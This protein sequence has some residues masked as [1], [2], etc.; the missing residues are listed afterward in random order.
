MDS[1]RIGKASVCIPVFNGMDNLPELIKSLREQELVE[2]EIVA[3][4][5]TS[6][7][8][9]WEYL[10]SQIDIRSTQIPTSEFSHGSTRQRLAEL[11]SNEVVIFLTQDATPSHSLFAYAHVNLHNSVGERVGAV[12]GTQIP[13]L[14]SPAAI[15]Q[16][17]KRTFDCLG[18]P[19]GIVIF[20]NDEMMKKIYRKRSIPFLSDVNVSYKKSVL[21][22][23]V[24]F[25][26]VSYAEDQLMAFDLFE[27][28]FEIVFSPQASVFH[29]NE[30]PPFK[31][32][33][34]IREEFVGAYGNLH[35]G[36]P[37]KSIVRIVISFIVNLRHDLI[38]LIKNRKR[39][40]WKWFVSE[41]LKCPIY[42]F[43]FEFGYRE[44]AK[45]LTEKMNN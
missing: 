15:A 39:A 25:Q 32:A 11:A 7:D 41:F 21:E 40:G 34:R 38:Y 20:R 10:S 8:G 13:R 14:N 12:L 28:G 30:I 26:N 27:A 45:L 19:T 33:V 35:S 31:Y 36:L 29:T 24:P 5:S 4:D 2:L 42:E 18:P 22:S 17:V 9:S 1:E 23:Q 6:T 43:Q 37:K 3:I 44:A 16:R